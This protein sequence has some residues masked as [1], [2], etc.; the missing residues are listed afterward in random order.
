MAQQ[1]YAS[2]WNK[3]IEILEENSEL[4]ITLLEKNK[5]ITDLKRNLT[6]T[7]NKVNTLR[8][9]INQINQL[10]INNISF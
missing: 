6:I 4:K 9:Q 8:Q 3:Y 10:I 2:L 5:T 7:E 1:Q